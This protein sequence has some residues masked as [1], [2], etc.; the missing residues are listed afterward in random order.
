MSANHDYFLAAARVW[1]LYFRGAI[2]LIDRDA[3]LKSLQARFWTKEG[4]Q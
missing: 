4:K 3:R 2:T 1:E